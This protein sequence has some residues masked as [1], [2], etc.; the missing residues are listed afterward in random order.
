MYV[1]R[2]GVKTAIFLAMPRTASKSCSVALQKIGATRI[3]EHHSIDQFHYVVKPGD[4]VM[5]TVRNHWD[6][7]VSFWYLNGCPERFDR[8]VPKLCR[9]SEWIDRNP[10]CTECR[11]YWKYAPLST[12]ILRYERIEQDINL[13]LQ[14][15]GFSAIKL[16]QEGPRKPKPY[17]VYYKQGIVNY[18]QSRF[19]REIEK[20]GYK[21]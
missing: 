16:K 15:Y 6:W 19:G 9:E 14:S 21:F 10:T 12:V 18:I 11:L 7:F 8:F 3:D 4:L 13:A 20:Y 2:N 1:L 17:Q 5:S